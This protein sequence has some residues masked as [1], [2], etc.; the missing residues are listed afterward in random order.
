MVVDKAVWVDVDASGKWCGGWI[1]QSSG[2]KKC[3]RG[4]VSGC[5]A[6]N[7]TVEVMDPPAQADEPEGWETLQAEAEGRSP[8]VDRERQQ[9]LPP[10]SPSHGASL[11]QATRQV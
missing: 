6:G 7:V 9:A 11:N 1:A 3:G 10:S 5:G 4:T 2:W 8:A